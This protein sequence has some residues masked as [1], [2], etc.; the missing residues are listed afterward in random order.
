M[1]KMM[2]MLAMQYGKWRTSQAVAEAIPA[3]Q[4]V[5]G[6]KALRSEISF[7]SLALFKPRLA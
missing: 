7:P 5:A 1:V 4:T 2:G 6:Q 3:K